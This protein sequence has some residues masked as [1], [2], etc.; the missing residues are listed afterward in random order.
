MMSSSSYKRE[1]S[2]EEGGGN[3]KGLLTKTAT[4]HV[5]QS[6]LYISLPPLHDYDVKMSITSRFTGDVNKQ[7]RNFLCLYK[8]ECGPQEISSKEIRLHKTLSEKWSKCDKV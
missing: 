8:V 5:H 7:R 3:E 1:F 2:N 6:F 4:W